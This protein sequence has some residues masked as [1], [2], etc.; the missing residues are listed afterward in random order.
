MNTL[1][2]NKTAAYNGALVAVAGVFVY[3]LVVM[4]YAITRSSAT[5]YHI[6]PTSERSTILLTNGFSIAY[7]VAVFSMIMA[8]VSL[9]AGAVGG[10]ILRNVLLRFNPQ[11]H[12]NKSILVSSIAAVVLLSVLYFLLYMLLKER[13]TY[14]YAGTFLFWYV[15]PSVIF[16]ISVVI[17]GA[18]LNNYFIQEKTNKK[19]NH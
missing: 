17:S 9:I 12:F 18:K 5:I 16:F 4:L 19:L 11:R 1:I 8:V 10:V 15:F 3:S 2:S 6:M 14:K 7:S 13:I